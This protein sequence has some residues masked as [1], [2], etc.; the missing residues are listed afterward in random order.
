MT[1]AD[2]AGIAAAFTLGELSMLGF[3]IFFTKP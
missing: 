1:L 2:L 3:V